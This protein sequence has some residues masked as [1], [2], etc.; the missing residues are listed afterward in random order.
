MIRKKI[1]INT[2][3][4]LITAEDLRASVPPGMTCVVKMV[5][6]ECSELLLLLNE[7]ICSICLAVTPR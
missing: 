7:N 4:I 1:V 5:V 2:M 6:N 3:I